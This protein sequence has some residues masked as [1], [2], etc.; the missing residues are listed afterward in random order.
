[1]IEPKCATCKSK[2]CTQ[3]VTDEDLLPSYCPTKNFR[4]LIE[5][6]KGKYQS[7]ELQN[8]FRCSALLEKECYDE[9]AAR[10][11]GRIVPLRPRIKEIAEFAKKI[12]AQKIGLAFCSGL[13]DEASRA[14]KILEGHRLDVVS[15][16]CSCGAIDK[17]DVGLPDEY[18]IRRPEN[19]EASCNPLMQAELLNRAGTAF[20]VIVGLCVGHDMLFAKHSEAPVTTLVVKDRFTGHNPVITLYSRYH[21]D[22]V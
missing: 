9:K 4:E 19:F 8:F 14:N 12:G 21:K 15:A 13:H 7:E 6:V 1:M 2:L 11:E 16:M 5:E 20:N 18:K 3:G 22:L 17:K 10:E